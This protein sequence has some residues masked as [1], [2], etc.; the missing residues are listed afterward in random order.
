M[1]SFLL[2][3]IEVM[4]GAYLASKGLSTIKCNI[5]SSQENKPL[6]ELLSDPSVINILGEAVTFELN[7][8][9]VDRVGYKLRHSSSHGALTD[10]EF[11]NDGV[12]IIW[13]VL[14][15]LLCEFK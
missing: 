9:L 2:P 15:K 10:T 3:I 14:I 4:L 11:H 5:D 12:K 7:F 13:W 1:W 8:L 6:S